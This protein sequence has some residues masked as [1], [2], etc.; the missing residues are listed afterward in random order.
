MTQAENPNTASLE[1]IINQRLSTGESFKKIEKDL[2]SKGYPIKEIKKITRKSDHYKVYSAYSV[3]YLYAIL[4][5]IAGILLSLSD[6]FTGVLVLSFAIIFL[7]LGIFTSRSHL[8]ALY[9]GL[10]MI[11]L[12]IIFNILTGSILPLILVIFFLIMAVKGVK[13]MK[14]ILDKGHKVTRAF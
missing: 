13:P 4:F 8:I 9:L 5:F 1:S 6:L 12:L 7:I 14:R 2:K 10:L 11:M 3:M